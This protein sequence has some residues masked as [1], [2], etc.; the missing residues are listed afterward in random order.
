MAKIPVPT[1]KLARPLTRVLQRG[2]MTNSRTMTN[3]VL[4]ASVKDA[5]NIGIVVV[6]NIADIPVNAGVAIIQ[7]LVAKEME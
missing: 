4:S 5:R 3:A 7:N 6:K 1:E 2:A